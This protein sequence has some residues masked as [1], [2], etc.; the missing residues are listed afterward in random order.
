MSEEGLK[1]ERIVEVYRAKD[2]MQAFLLAAELKN[3][4]I[5]CQVVGDRLGGAIGEIPMGWSTAPQILVKESDVPKARELLMEYEQRLA[6]SYDHD[7]DGE[8]DEEEYEEEYEGEGEEG[9]E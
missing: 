5:E 4:G 3:D 8:D 1:E 2:S 6:T 7:D 9:G